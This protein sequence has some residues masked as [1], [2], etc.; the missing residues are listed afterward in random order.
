MDVGECA[1]EPASH[2][3]IYRIIQDLLQKKEQSNFTEDFNYVIVKGDEREVIVILNLNSFSPDNRKEINTLSKSLTAK[4]KN[5]IGVFVFV[6][7]E[8]SSYYLS[9][10][11]KKGPQGH[12]KPLMKIYGKD[13]LFHKQGET[14]FLYSPLSFTQTNHSII[15]EFISTA[16]QLL[17]FNSSDFLL[18]LYCGYG[19]FALT[20]APQVKRILGI[21]LSRISIQDANENAI[22][23][24]LHNV[25]F[26][27]ADITP[28]SL[29]R[30][31]QPHKENLK[32]IIDPPRN[33]TAEGVIELLSE[34][35]PESVLH[36]F[37]NI[38]IIPKEL[39]RWKSCGYMPT[40][41]QP[42]DMFPGTDEIEMMILLKKK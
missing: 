6:D 11:P 34:F 39:Q 25:R 3:L 23:N 1:I 37:C 21:E 42:F 35:E 20:L 18:D 14:K 8:R 31:F 29:E 33:G 27:S 41:V 36:I 7:E 28:E 10:N 40:V 16:K 24:K 4:A 30:Y 12:P 5:V 22:R 17:N 19:L 9:G 13:K 32:I 2:A 38:D 15:D 26:V